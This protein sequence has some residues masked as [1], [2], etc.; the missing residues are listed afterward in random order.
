MKIMREKIKEI[1]GNRSNLK[2]DMY[3]LIQILN[4]VEWYVIKRFTIQYNHE[5]QRR[6]RHRGLKEVIIKL[7]ENGLVKLST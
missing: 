4:K 6:P 7:K 5:K 3:D 2:M 1:M